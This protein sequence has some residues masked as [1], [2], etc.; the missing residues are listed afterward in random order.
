MSQTRTPADFNDALAAWKKSVA[1]VIAKSRRIDPSELP[2]DAFTTYAS[3]TADGLVINPLYTRA[4]EQAHW[5]APG[6]FPYVRGARQA[7]QPDNGWHV[8]QKMRCA[9]GNDGIIAALETGVSSLWLS[10]SSD[11][12]EAALKDVY[13]DL[14]PLVFSGSDASASLVQQALDILDARQ[15]AGDN[16]ADRSHITMDF[17]IDPL[18]S[19]WENSS[20]LTVE[21]AVQIATTLSQR[22]ETLR[23]L[24]A[25][26]TVYHRAGASDGQELAIVTSVALSYVK[27]LITSGLSAADA[28]AQVSFRIAVTDNQFASIAKVR[29]LRLMWAT[30]AQELAG[31]APAAAHIHAVTSEPMLTQRDPWVN[32]LRVTLACFGAGVGGANAITVL[33]FDHNL[34]G[35]VDGYSASFADRVARNTQ[36]LLVEESHLGFVQDPAG[37]AWFVESHTADLAEHAWAF[38]QK[39][40]AAGGFTSAVE[41]SMLTAEIEKIRVERDNDIA[42]RKI[43]ITGVNEFPNLDEPALTAEQRAVTGYRYGIAFETLRN[44]SDAYLEQQGAR[45][46]AALIPLGSVAEHNG[47][48]TFASNLLA[49]GGIEAVNPGPVTVEDLAEKIDVSATKIAIICGTDKRYGTDAAQMVSALHAAGISQ[50]LIAGPEKAYPADATDKPEGFV[51]M[52]IDAVAVLTELLGQ[53]GVK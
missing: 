4:D 3:T 53:L 45:P 33:P 52:K 5:P 48:T 20:T 8:C 49:S 21:E 11:C 16:V 26:G 9:E 46:S 6:E 28:L 12:L 35:G 14:A 10:C 50:V 47:R 27:T 36:L 34:P 30:V 22:E 19:Q 24:V 23:A 39:I 31:E 18:G 41:S 32:M 25:D 38:F 44:R 51:H 40:E 15:S 1:A 37:G 7:T 17:C 42:H 43:S 29:A 13:L 2:E